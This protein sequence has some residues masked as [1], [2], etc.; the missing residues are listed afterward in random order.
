MLRVHFTSDDLARVRVATAPD[1]LWEITDSF[2]VLASAREGSPAFRAWRRQTRLRLPPPAD[3]SLDR[4][5]RL[6][7]RLR[8]PPPELLPVQREILCDRV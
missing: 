6:A 3:G 4:T 5:V 7:Q 8:P 1:P 2:Q